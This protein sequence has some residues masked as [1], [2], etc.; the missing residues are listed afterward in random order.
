MVYSLKLV[1]IG[2][3]TLIIGLLVIALGPFDRRGTRAYF[4]ARLW[5]RAILK[6]GGVRLNVRGLEHLDPTHPYIVMANHRSYIDIPVLLEAFA[7]FQLR[8]IAKK[9]L[10][11]VPV[12]GWALWASKHIIMDRSGRAQA[13]ASLR[14]A[15]EKIAQGISVVIFPEGTRGRSSGILPF[16]RGG[17]VLAVMADV[18]IVP[19][20]IVGSGAVLPRGEWR[21][22]SGEIE[23]VVDEPIRMERYDLKSIGKLSTRVRSLMLSH[24]NRASAGREAGSAMAEE[25]PSGEAQARG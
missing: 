25:E 7:R 22:R 23:V 8:L 17:F 4:L 9:E 18:P 13:M 20:T 1:L 21:I 19:V 12:F 15:K 2:F 11:W 24:L 3:L 14:R 10:V 5:T 16:K 6:I